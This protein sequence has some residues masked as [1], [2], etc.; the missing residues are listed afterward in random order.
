MACIS[1]QMNG[2]L[3]RLDM[4]MLGMPDQVNKYYTIQYNFLIFTVNV[5]ISYVRLAGS[6][7]N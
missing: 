5:T 6:S 4:N 2:S 1:E 7:L 3:S